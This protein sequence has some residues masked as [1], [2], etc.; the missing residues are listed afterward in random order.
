MPP[1]GNFSA[2][3][4]KHG[5]YASIKTSKADATKNVLQDRCADYLNLRQALPV[6]DAEEATLPPNPLNQ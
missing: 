6:E 2:W 5:P 4:E 3:I 1:N